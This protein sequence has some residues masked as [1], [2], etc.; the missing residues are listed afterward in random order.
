MEYVVVA[1]SALTDSA[2][3]ADM[4]LPIAQW[5]ELEEVANAGQC[6]SLHY[7][8]K[9]I[10]PLFESKP[11]TQI[12]TELAD[13]LGLGQYFTLSNEEILEEIYN[14]EMGTALGM[15]MNDLREKKQVRFI[16]GDAETDPHIAYKDGAFGT[17]SGRFEFYREMPTVRAATTK[18][19]TP[20]EIDRDR[21]AHWF[22]P[23]EAWP[24]NELYSKY[25]LVLMSERPRYRVHSQWFNTPLLREIDTEPFVKI[26][27]V[28]AEA[29]GI[30][31]GSY[32]EC[33]NDRGTAVAKAVFSEA[34]RP[35][36]LL[37]PK[38]WQLNQ[39]KAGGWSLLS[40]TEFDVFAVNNNF[41]DVLCDVR[42]WEGSDE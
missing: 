21:M 19:P 12:V 37:Y 22:P 28:D 16:P 10:E 4:V 25:P 14:T 5:F 38:G 36:T 1:D 27:P 35:G 26:N 8:E 41:M 13:K 9:A 34:I 3:Y 39:H 29:R 20:E 31:D 7:N 2:R 15:S 42:V 30:T 6:S 23:L 17:A 18:T 11:D 33:F 24:E 32:V 40:S